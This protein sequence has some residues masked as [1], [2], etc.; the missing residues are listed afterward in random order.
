[1]TSTT[2]SPP[3]ARRSRL[4][5][6][7]HPGGIV[8]IFDV[9]DLQPTLAVGDV[10]VIAVGDGLLR[11]AAL[12]VTDEAGRAL[13]RHVQHLETTPPVEHVDVVAACPHAPGRARRVVAAAR[14][15]MSGI[16]DVDAMYA[17]E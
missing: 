8:R 11:P 2:A 9:D 4:V 3:A 10:E 16:A 12:G 1:M 13:D 7:G 5:D 14:D 17:R 15:R 6:A